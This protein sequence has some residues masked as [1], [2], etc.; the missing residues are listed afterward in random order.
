MVSQIQSKT[1]NQS[2]RFLPGIGDRRTE[3]LHKIG[4]KTVYDLLTNFPRKYLDRTRINK[5]A[6]TVAGNN[7]E[8]FIPGKLPF[9]NKFV[10]FMGKI[11]LYRI[12]SDRSFKFDSKKCIRCGTCVSVCPMNNIEIVDNRVTWNHNC[13]CCLACIHWCPRNA[14]EHMKT[15]GIPRY[16]HPDIRVKQIEAYKLK[17]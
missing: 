10:S 7:I 3:L 5:I 6:E 15:H 8:K 13:E 4:I 16:H 12:F 14:I 17:S 2:V 11:F 1:L 9:K